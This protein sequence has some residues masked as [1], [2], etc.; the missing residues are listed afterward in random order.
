MFCTMKHS[1]KQ[2]YDNVYQSMYILESFLST[3]STDQ[4]HLL[5]Q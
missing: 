1:V 3:L 4:L 5:A 2:N